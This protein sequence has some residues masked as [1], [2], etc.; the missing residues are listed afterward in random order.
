MQPAL[1]HKRRQQ[2]SQCLEESQPC[3]RELPRLHGLHVEDAHHL[4]VPDER[5]GAHRG[6]ASLVHAA[7]P[8]EVRVLVHVRADDGRARLGGQARDAASHLQACHA[9]GLKVQAIRGRQRHAAAIAVGQVEGADI[10]VCGSLRPV[11]DGAHELV[12]RACR[13]GQVRDL[14]EEA[15]LLE[16]RRLQLTIGHRGRAQLRHALM[17]DRARRAVKPCA[18][19]S[20]GAEGRP[21][22]TAMWPGPQRGTRRVAQRGTGLLR[23]RHA[24]RGGRLWRTPPQ[25]ARRT[26]LRALA[27]ASRRDGRPVRN[28]STTRAHSRPSLMAHTTSDWPRRI[29]PATKTPSREVR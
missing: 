2:A 14:R 19:G 15:D 6:E 16:M 9:H 28:W 18:L 22:V 1:L 12:P 21:R 3:G 5:D 26:S 11:D 29:S 27:R 25:L 17:V 13:G 20:A 23:R 4:L 7:D 10:S 24:A 8:G